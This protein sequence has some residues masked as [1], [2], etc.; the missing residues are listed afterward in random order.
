M[1]YTL[2]ACQH[3]QEFFIVDESILELFTNLFVFKTLFDFF[4]VHFIENSPRYVNETRQ[5]G[6]IDRLESIFGV[7]N[8][9]IGPT[10]N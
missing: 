9:N 2:L 7:H 1:F 4:G 8:I 3:F 6:E 5:N 10:C